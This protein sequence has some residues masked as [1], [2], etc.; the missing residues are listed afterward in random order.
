MA[1]MKALGRYV[2]LVAGLSAYVNAARAAES[3]AAPSLLDF[4]AANHSRQFAAAP[5][6]VL[7]FY[8]TWY[9]RPENHGSWVHW[10]G[11]DPTAHATPQTTH[12]PARG[13]YESQDPALIDAHLAEAKASGLTGF[14]ATWWGRDSYED[15]AFG[16]LLD[17]AEKASF[18]ATVY[19][20]TAP[21]QGHEQIDRA[22]SDLAY[23][24]SH[25]GSR[26]PFLK[27][28]GKPV[29]FVYGRV[30]GEVPTAS[31]PAILTE[32][33]AKVGDFL[34]IADGYGTSNARLF[35]GV[36]EY[37]NCGDVAGKSPDDLRAWSARHYAAAI[38][39]A[40]GQGKISCV[41]VIPGYDD[42]KIRHPGLKAER[43]DGQTY[44][45]L[46]EEAIRAN[47][48]WVLITTWNEWHEGS[49]IEPSWEDHDKYLR[50]TAE[51]A[52][53]FLADKTARPPAANQAGPTTEQKRNLQ[54]LFAGRTIGL[55]PDFGDA[56]FWL[57]DAG[58][59]VKELTWA[60]VA[61]AGVLN[62]KNFPLVFH[63]GGESYSATGQA[64]GDVVPALQ[65]YLAQGGF[66]VSLPR[67]PFPFYYDSATSQAQPVADQIGLPVRQGWEQPPAG[68]RLT[69]HA[70]GHLPDIP[71]I[72]PFPT[73]GDLR[74]RPADSAAIRR[75]DSY[76]SLVSLND[77]TGHSYGDAIA[78]V[79]HLMPPLAT[80][81]TLYV[82]MRMPD[83]MGEDKL[84][85]A[86]FQ[87]AGER[88]PGAA[89]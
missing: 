44:R 8:Y 59:S 65:H 33:R 23:L 41:T 20:E 16:L 60:D 88:L 17:R 14:I 79:K 80:G 21:G 67:L 36:H 13:A 2:L 3:V 75:G 34:L 24:V 31:W 27:V 86:V 43:Q 12:Y 62:P 4:V 26:P 40:R 56:A 22:V 57:L 84:L 35:D 76:E 71:S 10:G 81:Q 25:Y 49:E 28:Q 70:G 74:W 78:Y 32:A 18:K 42:T 68:I 7:A 83:V 73:T 69:F 47:P 45:V 37:N 55:L 53:R 46:W 6:E 58:L 30:M 87:F 29:I 61:D 54:R 64:A 85:A 72:T 66:L 50:L 39:L 82:W 63:N 89:K 9:G 52:P 51:F 11:D 15:K 48:D 1:D 77:N 19:W 38:R 5:R